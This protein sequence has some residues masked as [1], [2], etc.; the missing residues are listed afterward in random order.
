LFATAVLLLLSSTP[1]PFILEK[2]LR[3]YPL[4]TWPFVGMKEHAGG[5]VSSNSLGCG[6]QKSEI[7]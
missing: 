6:E 4:K 3:V 2:L 1:A 5:V 7:L